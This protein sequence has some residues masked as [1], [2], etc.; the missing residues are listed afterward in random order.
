MIRAI[1][2][3][4]FSIVSDGKMSWWAGCCSITVKGV[5]EVRTE[6]ARS[7]R[8]NED[9][10]FHGTARAIRLIDTLLNGKNE[11]IPNIYREFSGKFPKHY[12][13]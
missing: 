6:L 7:G 9:L 11:N 8:K 5:F 4:E 13:T 2:V 12:F 1:E 10:V 3:V